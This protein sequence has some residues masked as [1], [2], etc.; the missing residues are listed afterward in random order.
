MYCG[1]KKDTKLVDLS[2]YF[3]F[4]FVYKISLDHDMKGSCINF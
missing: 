1:K 4:Q 3:Y 2:K